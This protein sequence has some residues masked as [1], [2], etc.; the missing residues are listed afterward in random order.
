MSSKRRKRN[1]IC[2]SLNDVFSKSGQ[3]TAATSMEDIGSKKAKEQLET[4]ASAPLAKLNSNLVFREEILTSQ[5]VAYT[6][7]A[8]A[9][10]VPPQAYEDISLSVSTPVIG[11]PGGASEAPELPQRNRKDA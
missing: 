8:T 3:V 1:K 2:A 9:D 4:T 10:Q 5:C 7:T 6:P 11:V